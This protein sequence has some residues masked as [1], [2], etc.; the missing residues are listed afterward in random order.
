L[1]YVW[2]VVNGCLYVISQ[3]EVLSAFPASLS[4]NAET[5]GVA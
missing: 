1:V 3:N 2:M 5:V 4:D